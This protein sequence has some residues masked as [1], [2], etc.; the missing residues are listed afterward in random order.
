MGKGKLI[1]RTNRCKGCEI[2]ISVCPKKVLELDK[3]NVNKKGY[4]P[5]CITNEEECMGCASCAL[6]CPD[7]VINVYTE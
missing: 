6:M 3:F 4:H 5:I 7:G 1:L 2:C